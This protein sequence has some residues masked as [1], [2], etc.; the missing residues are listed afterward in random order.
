MKQA[1]DLAGTFAGGHRARDL[2]R[3]TVGYVAQRI[4]TQ[5]RIALRRAGLLVTKNLPNEIE[6]I[7]GG[8][9]GAGVGMSQI[10]ESHTVEPGPAPDLIPHW[11]MPGDRWP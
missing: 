6:A 7:A 4:V 3:G 8:D 5:M 2:L 11:T 1:D 10:M 9:R